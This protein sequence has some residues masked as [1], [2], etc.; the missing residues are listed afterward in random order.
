MATRS[1]TSVNPW[2]P[3][4]PARRGMAPVGRPSPRR[5]EGGVHVHHATFSVTGV[6]RTYVEPPTVTE[7]PPTVTL[8]TV[9]VPPAVVMVR[10]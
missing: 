4:P 3:G 10:V 9:V 2:S 8:G 7:L 1:S 6:G 5:V